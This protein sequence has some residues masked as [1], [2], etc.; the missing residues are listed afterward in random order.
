MSD[1]AFYSTVK[2]GYNEL[3]NKSVKR[4]KNFNPKSFSTLVDPVLTNPELSWSELDVEWV[5]GAM[6]TSL[7]NP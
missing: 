1:K 2:L 6:L 3:G 7:Q 4:K 5:P